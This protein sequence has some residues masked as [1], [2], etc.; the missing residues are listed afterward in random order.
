DGQFAL[1]QSLAMLLW[2]RLLRIWTEPIDN[3]TLLCNIEH[4]R[5]QW[6]LALIEII[7][8]ASLYINTEFIDFASPHYSGQAHAEFY[9]FALNSFLRTID[10]VQ[11]QKL[12]FFG[13]DL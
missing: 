9:L 5:R 11:Y 4:L 3:L 1:H 2:G 7:A 13:F 10:W 6:P 8:I 12:F